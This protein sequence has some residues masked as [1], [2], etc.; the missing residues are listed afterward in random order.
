MQ[1][2]FRVWHLSALLFSLSIF[3]FIY[4]LNV[5]DGVNVMF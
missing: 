1:H 3:V 2:L 4:L 5:I